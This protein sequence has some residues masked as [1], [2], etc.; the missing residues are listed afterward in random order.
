MTTGKMSLIPEKCAARV[1]PPTL[2]LFYKDANAG[3][4]VYN[5]EAALPN[6]FR[7]KKTTFYAIAEIYSRCEVSN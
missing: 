2:V 6:F 3:A 1:S 5:I 7:E 4:L